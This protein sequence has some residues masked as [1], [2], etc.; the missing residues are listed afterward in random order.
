MKLL[1]QLF[2]SLNQHETTTTRSFLQN[3]SDE[4]L[5]SVLQTHSHS[6]QTLL[7]EQQNKKEHPHWQ[8]IHYPERLQQLSQLT[9][10]L[11][12]KV[13]YVRC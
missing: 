9:P 6:L 3:Y 7:R 2:S 11:F 1:D 10:L 5:L 12:E 13:S 8:S 4:D